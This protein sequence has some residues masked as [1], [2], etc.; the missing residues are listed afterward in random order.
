MLVP[1]S[2]DT[3]QVQLRQACAELERCLSAGEGRGAEDLLTEFPAVAAH[4]ESALELIYTEFVVR[5]RLG[6]RPLIGAWYV[7]FP[8]W[9]EDLR[10]LFLV[11]SLVCDSGAGEQTLGA[12]TPPPGGENSTWDGGDEGPGVALP[13]LEAYELLGE[14]ARGGMGVVYKARQP[15][16]DRLVALKMIRAG[17]GAAA[18]DLA[19]FR[20]EAAAVAA[21]QHPN[22]VQIYE[23]GEWQFGAGSPSVPFLSLEFVDGGSLQQRLAAGVLPPPGAA[24]V[25]EA[26]AGAVHY[27]HKQGIL[28]RDLKPANIL[29]TQG[30]VPKIT[31]FGLAKRLGEGGDV[32]TRTGAV[33]GTPAY[34]APEQADGKSREVGETADVYSLGAILYEALTGRPPFQGESPLHTLELVRTQEPVPPRR[35][36]PTIPPDLQTICLKCLRKEPAR[37]YADAEALADDLRRFQSGEAIQARPVGLVEGMVKR[38]RRR[39]ALAALVVV[40]GLALITLLAVSLRYNALLLSA[41]D[42]ARDNAAEAQQAGERAERH[43]QRARRLVD[44]LTSEAQQAR[45]REDP[46]SEARRRALLQEALDSCK[47]F[48]R[49]KPG[50]AAVR[51][52]TARACSQLGFCLAEQNDHATAVP[53]Y[54]EGVA[55]LKGLVAE[56]PANRQYRMELSGMLAW[57]GHALRTIGKE[58]QADAVYVRVIALAEVL[59]REKPSDRDARMGLAN[60]LLN[61]CV[62]MRGDGRFAEAERATFRAM[63]LQRA[64]LKDHPEDVGVLTELGLSLD[65]MSLLM[66]LKRPPDLQAAEDYGYQALALRQRLVKRSDTTYQRQALTNTSLRLGELLRINRRYAE[67]VPVYR[68]AERSLNTLITRFPNKHGYREQLVQCQLYLGEA[69]RVDCRHADAVPVYRAAERSLNTLITR[70]PKNHGYREQLV[71]CQSGLGHAFMRTGKVPEAT[72]AYRQ[73]L[74]AYDKL[75]AAGKDAVV[76]RHEAA[77]SANNLASFLLK[78]EQRTPD[79]VAEALALAKR[80]VQLAPRRRT[81]WLTLAQAQYESKDPK[82]AWK[83]FLEALKLEARDSE[84]YFRSALSAGHEGN[85]R[86]ARRLYD[87][88]VRRLKGQESEDPVVARVRAEVEVLIGIGTPGTAKPAAAPDRGGR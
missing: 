79:E 57:L 18:D 46:Q 39:P 73:A 24:A 30:G 48:L 82:A 11:H 38:C 58:G 53:V 54:Q 43:L 41:L 26:L 74:A 84:S 36:Q 85:F 8:Q 28:H 55:L 86:E 21:L 37:R 81:C 65:D 63:A 88:G 20:T 75:P 78:A 1:P 70:F 23:V 87:E 31:D 45:G 49:E 10:Q 60:I 52:D 15:G 32:Q 9:R 44:Q 66:H 7:R 25:V 71:Q 35:L 22:I 16:L 83:S 3:T 64:V 14:I 80:A 17:E 4:Q 72:A 51:F 40:S 68:E 2:D 67:A 76:P 6:Q 61:R 13:R 59:L 34:M 5:Q 33:V 42:T 77:L 56:S 29:L 62:L 47:D 69:L 50:D 19:R 12:A 27:A